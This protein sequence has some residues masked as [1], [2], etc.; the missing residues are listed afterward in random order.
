VIVHICP[1]SDL[2]AA[3][4]VGELRPDSL[5]AIGFVHCSDPGTAH[6]PATALFRGHQDLVLLEIDPERVP[7]PVRWEPG[8]RDGHVEDPSGPWFPHVYGPVPW[9]AVV[10]VHPFPPEHDGTFRPPTSLTHRWGDDR[11]PR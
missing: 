7:A 11:Q 2:D 1:R 10:A 4:A 8:V 3:R 5:P 9:A 6:L